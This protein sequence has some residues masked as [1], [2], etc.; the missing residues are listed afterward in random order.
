MAG[1]SIAQNGLN[2]LVNDLVCAIISF[3]E[4][5]EAF[6][7]LRVSKHYA[8]VLTQSTSIWKN[9]VKIRWTPDTL[10]ALNITDFMDKTVECKEHC[11][12]P[13]T[14]TKMDATTKKA[15]MSETSA[16]KTCYSKIMSQVKALMMITTPCRAQPCI[17]WGIFAK[18]HYCLSPSCLAKRGLNRSAETKAPTAATTD[19]IA[20]L[21]ANIV[22]SSRTYAGDYVMRERK[23]KTNAARAEAIAVLSNMCLLDIP[24]WL[25]SVHEFFR[26]NFIPG[27]HL[28]ALLHVLFI[29][30]LPAL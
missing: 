2:A 10:I 28:L 19:A 14:E 17:G 7:L 5:E 24:R 20:S 25:T 23:I 30:V 3:T 8:E 22:N 1:T 4:L 26:C 18:R 11:E 13:A 9:M 29:M 6:K 16:P 15:K 12:P 21:E 27:I